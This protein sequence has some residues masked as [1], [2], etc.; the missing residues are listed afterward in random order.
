MSPEEFLDWVN[1]VEEIM[2]FKEVPMERRVPLVATRNRHG[3]TKI[4]DWEKLKKK[5]QVEFLPHNYTR[6]MYQRLQNLRQNTRSVDDYTDEFYQ[7]V[8]RN[9]LSETQEQLILRR[10][11]S[12]L[13]STARASAGAAPP[14]RAVPSQPAV[15]AAIKPATSTYKCFKCGEPGHRM[16]DCRKGDRPGKALFVEPDG[17]I[18]DSAE[19]YDQEA[20]FD[21]GSE[22]MEEI[23]VEGDTGPLLVVRRTTLED[24]VMAA[25]LYYDKS[26]LDVKEAAQIFFKALDIDEDGQVSQHEFIPVLN[27]QGQVKMANGYFFKIF[28]KDGKGTLEFMEVMTIYYIIKSGRPFCMGCGEF[29]PGIYFPCYDCFEEGVL[30]CVCPKCFQHGKFFHEH[31]NFVDNYFMLEAKRM[32]WIAHQH[33]HQHKPSSSVTELPTPTTNNVDPYK[34]NPQWDNVKFEAA[35]IALKALDIVV[36]KSIDFLFLKFMAP[37]K[38]SEKNC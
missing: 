31:S 7:L 35:G 8:A 16:A 36:M 27:Q 30:F 29:I 19:G 18:H 12:S 5:M 22:E 26:S 4:T 34:P 23:V 17:A 2:E 33:Q 10:P 14:T 25:T 6:I 32:Q 37:L 9:D 21:D 1:A 11:A 28:D 24:L 20:V 13:G 3:K 38:L 15:P